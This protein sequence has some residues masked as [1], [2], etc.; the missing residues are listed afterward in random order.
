MTI[1]LQL[2]ARKL[3]NGQTNPKNYPWA[4]QLVH[5]LEA[6]GHKVIQV[7][8]NEDDQICDDFRH[9]LSYKQVLTLIRDSDT[10]ISVDT[11]LQHAGWSVG[12]KGI[13]LW[14]QSDPEIFGHDC[15]VNLLRDRGTL[16]PNQFDTY[17]G[18]PCNNSA[19]H[20]PEEVMEALKALE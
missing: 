9:G 6:E 2:V 19:F 7:G 11:F 8:G 17:E 14:A 13:V 18:Y 3:R 4:S 5:L 10:F 15:H 12:K 20:T 1:L 16:R